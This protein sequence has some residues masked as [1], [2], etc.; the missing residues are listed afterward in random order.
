[1]RVKMLMIRTRNKNFRGRPTIKYARRPRQRCM[2]LLIATSLVWSGCAETETVPERTDISLA[3]RLMPADACAGDS[4]VHRNLAVIRHGVR[5]ETLT[6]VAPVSVL[7]SLPGVSGNLTLEGLATPVFNIGD[8]VE[9]NL[10][11]VRGGKRNL[12]GRRF[13]DSGRRAEDRAWIPIAFPLDLHAGDQL[14]IDVCAGP[15]GD[16]VAD[17]LALSELRLVLRETVQ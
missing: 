10:F 7:A 14:E 8:G 9:M 13:F 16:L 17:W 1:M 6:L 2:L 12:I 15:Q 11:L 4:N 3:D 5:K